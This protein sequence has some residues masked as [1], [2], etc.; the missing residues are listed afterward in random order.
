VNGACGLASEGPE[1]CRADSGFSWGPAKI[2]EP[3]PPTGREEGGRDQRGHAGSGRVGRTIRFSSVVKFAA[4]NFRYKGCSRRSRRRGP[5][6]KPRSRCRR[7]YFYDGHG[8]PAVSRR[9]APLGEFCT[10]D[11]GVYELRRGSRSPR[12][13]AGATSSAC[14]ASAARSS[15]TGRA[16]RALEK[17]RLLIE[18]LARLAV[19]MAGRTSRQT[20]AARQSQAP[21]QRAR[22]P[23]DRASS[24]ITADFSH[25]SAFRLPR[26]ARRVVYFPRFDDSCN[27]AGHDEGPGVPLSMTGRRP[28]RRHTARWLVGPFD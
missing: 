4:V 1:A 3:R 26:K 28:G 22:F 9:S 6:E 2:E 19:Y 24:A 13:R 18:A 23:K 11:A 14:R 17:T 25:R 10:P 15:S 8:Q 21:L 16:A 27:P 12:K 5:Q 20:R 7:S